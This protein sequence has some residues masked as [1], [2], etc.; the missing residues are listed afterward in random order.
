MQLTRSIATFLWARAVVMEVAI[1]II[2]RITKI[3][4]RGSFHQIKNKHKESRQISEINGA[5]VR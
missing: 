2:M 3:V 4:K 1:A 5:S